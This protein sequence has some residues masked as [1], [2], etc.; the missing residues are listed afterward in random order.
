M[1]T[2]RK[3]PQRKAAVI[4]PGNGPARAV[5][6][7]LTNPKAA[8][9]PVTRGLSQRRSRARTEWSEDYQRRR[10]E[11]LQAAATVFLH[12]GLAEATL[13]D[14]ADAAGTDRAT[15]YYY[16]KNKQELFVEVIRDS[17]IDAET[18]AAAIAA[19]PLAPLD[20]LRKLIV[21]SIDSYTR[22]YP[23]LYIYA[24]ED[25][26][27]LDLESPI[28][29]ELAQRAQRIFDM[30]RVAIVEGLDDGSI[31]SGMTPGVLAQIL[32]GVSAWSHRWLQPE[33][34]ADP[35][36]SGEALADLMLSGLAAVRSQP[37]SH[38]AHTPS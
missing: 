30:Y 3:P 32:V 25:L 29:D 4:P 13:A 1:V 11:L 37:S 2:D 7:T 6:A 28:E 26:T 19:Q 27:R 31:V 8:S 35:G 9:V 18:S 12:K 36:A 38:G 23:Y 15:V 14:I 21:N 10:A 5:K 17:L 33:L 16:V 34:G 20:K 22:H 24:V